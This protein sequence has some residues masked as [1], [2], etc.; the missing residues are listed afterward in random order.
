MNYKITETEEFKEV[1]RRI[2][3]FPKKNSARVENEFEDEK[4]VMAFPNLVIR[5]VIC[6]QLV[7]ILVSLAA[8]FIDAPLEEIAN[9]Q[10]TPNPAKAPWYF[11]GLQ[12]LLHTFPP[13]VAGVIMPALVII[14]LLVIPYFDINLKGDGLWKDNVKS[15]FT[16]V[17]TLSSFM[18]I[19][20][21]VMDAFTVS[22]PTFI[23]YFFMIAPLM[24]KKKNKF[25]NWLGK[26]SLSDW[27]MTWFVIISIELTIIGTYFRGPGWSWVS[28]F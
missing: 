28:P 22:I 20:M 3:V 23:I 17:T 5:E 9:P 2:A 12:E 1:T 11:L 21:S 26:A 6:F 13:L 10:N 7:V 24:I 4:L 15:T 14:A 25:I 27:I 19:L 8:L 16:V 18:I